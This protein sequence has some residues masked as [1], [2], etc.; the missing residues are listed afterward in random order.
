M[1]A[2]KRKLGILLFFIFILIIIAFF[3]YRSFFVKIPTCFDNEHN[4]IEEGV[5][6]GGGCEQICKVQ[7][8]KVNI[9]WAKTFKVAH[10]V[11]NVAALIENPNFDFN[12]S[13]I[14]TIKIFDEE[15]I[16]VKDFTK[17]IKLRPGEKR[18]IFIP[19]IITGK[20]NIAQTFIDF[21][22][23]ESLTLGDSQK[24][25]INVISK[26]LVQEKNQTRLSV[27]I[28]NMGLRSERDIEISAVLIGENESIIDVGKTFVDYI[29]KR[30][31]KKVEI[32]WPKIFDEDKIL[33]DVYLRKVTL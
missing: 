27:E 7:A 16:R 29:E 14:Y 28:K 11:S 31:E 18:I 22:D 12:M 32:T 33:I 30:G 2:V 6:C 17:K 10:G 19:S 8:T 20:K 21:E 24:S 15:G 1:W 4:G 25:S 5:D 23:I 3:V 13:A 9:I 26:T